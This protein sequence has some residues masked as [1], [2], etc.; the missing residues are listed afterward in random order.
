MIHTCHPRARPICAAMAAFWLSAAIL[1]CCAPGVC[2][3][4]T[5]RPGIGGTHRRACTAM[6]SMPADVASSA[7]PD[8]GSAESLRRM[9][10]VSIS[11]EERAGGALLPEN[12]RVAADVVTQHGVKPHMDGGHLFHSTHGFSLHTPVHI[13]NVLDSPPS[14]T[15]IKADLL[16][17]AAEAARHIT[18]GFSMHP[19]QRARVLDA[20]A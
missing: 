19:A 7:A 2:A 15:S 9:L 13:V 20:S 12:L 11:D 10:T 6:L 8:R 4:S 3:W 17:S 18:P 14:Q 16:Q 1:A 5:A